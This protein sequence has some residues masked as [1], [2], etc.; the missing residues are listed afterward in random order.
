MN[1]MKFVL[2][3][4]S[5]TRDVLVRRLRSV[6]NGVKRRMSR[7]CLKNLLRPPGSVIAKCE[8]LLQS[9]VLKLTGRVR[10]PRSLWSLAMTVAFWDSLSLSAHSVISAM[11]YI[12]N[13]FSRLYG[14]PTAC[15]G[16]SNLDSALLRKTHPDRSIEKVSYHTL[17]PTLPSC[18]R[19]RA[20]SK[21]L[22][23][24]DSRFRGNDAYGC[25]SPAATFKTVPKGLAT[26]FVMLVLSL[27]LFSC[28]SNQDVVE[29][30]RPAVAV[31]AVVIALTDEEIVKTYTG[32]LEG[33]KQAV[34]YAKIAEAVDTVRVR[35]GQHVKPDQVLISLDRSGP[36]S[37][38]Q[39][40][41]SLYRNAEKNYKKMEYLFNEGA[42]S[43]SQFD[44]AKTQYEVYKAN[45][46]AAK[47]L[48]DIQSPI[49][50]VVT[51]LKVSKGDF[52]GPGQELATIATVE[53]LRVK[54]GVNAS[55]IG[56]VIP[57][58]PVTVS[59]S[60][61]DKKV[62]GNVLSVAGSADPITRTFQVE[63]VFDNSEVALRPGQFA[64]IDIPLERLT[65]VVV[66]PRQAVLARQE[67][68]VV[69]VVSNG[70]AHEREV[71]TGKDLD[72]RIVVSS[73]LNVGDTLVTLGQNYLQ[74]EVEVIIT[75]LFEGK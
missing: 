73:G 5:W 20:S 28:G 37:R 10:S 64:R 38:Y 25:F 53:T 54:F 50:G 32:T 35:E 13:T 26:G 18:P 30:E 68:S 42:V 65:G 8:A 1:K 12:L 46:E 56:S 6:R 27:S 48:V 33:E 70:V 43:E 41:L 14:Y 57:G 67:G 15:G 62:M 60:G 39:E 23:D 61:E 59:I 29:K 74:E 4:F 21:A 40:V 51:S 47:Q 9:L 71:I 2:I 34:I 45:F 55:E 17:N 63:V 31:K 75:D 49:D 7:G 19:R 44:A 66:V 11:K 72:G 3:F 36:S 22:G 58:M 69:F 52:L 16:M 24:L